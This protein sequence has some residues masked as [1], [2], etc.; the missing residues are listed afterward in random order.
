MLWNIKLQ[1]YLY[2]NKWWQN[3][4]LCPLMQEARL[5]V[6]GQRFVKNESLLVFLRYLFKPTKLFNTAGLYFSL[7]RS[8]IGLSATV[9]RI[10]LVRS[11]VPAFTLT[12]FLRTDWSVTVKHKRS[13]RR[14][15]GRPVTLQKVTL[16]QMWQKKGQKK[17]QEENQETKSKQRTSQRE[18]SGNKSQKHKDRTMFLL[19]SKEQREEN[20]THEDRTSK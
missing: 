19:L 7:W 18:E 12:R 20:K 11:Q 10:W 15:T 3:Q 5:R 8:W 1:I 4:S 17:H 9:Q 6:N 2:S 13:K 16:S 14:H